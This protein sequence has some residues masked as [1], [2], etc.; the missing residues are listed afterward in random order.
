MVVVILLLPLLSSSKNL[1]IEGSITN[2]KTNEK[3]AYA[4]V[5]ISGTYIGTVSNLNGEFRLVVPESLSNKSISFGFR[6]IWYRIDGVSV[7]AICS[8]L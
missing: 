5:A 2:H 1:L 8:I 7:E 4:N 6:R 3:I